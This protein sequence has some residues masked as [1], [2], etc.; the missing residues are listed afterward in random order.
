MSDNNCIEYTQD[1]PW[2]CRKRTFD[3]FHDINFD[4][5]RFRQTI[6]DNFQQYKGK[7]LN[8]DTEQ[9]KEQQEYL[10]QPQQQFVPRF[11]NFHNQPNI[12]NLLVFHELGSGKTCTSI[13]IGEAYKAFFNFNENNLQADIKKVFVVTPKSVQSEYYRE[14]SGQCVS[15]NVSLSNGYKVSY[16]SFGFGADTDEIIAERNRETLE[17]Y[18]RQENEKSSEQKI[19]KYWEITS[20]QKF[21]NRLF[22]G[23]T[24]NILESYGEKI[25]KGGY[26][27]IIDEIQNLVSET[28]ERYKKLLYFLN[29]FGKTNKIIL[30]S[31]TPIYDK[32]FELGL[33]IN[34]LNP[35]VFFPRTQEGFNNFFID[36]D[37]T[38]NESS[39]EIKNKALLQWMC[40][41]YVSYFSGGNPI[42]FPRKRIIEVFHRMRKYQLSNYIENV[43][44]ELSKNSKKGRRKGPVDIHDTYYF[45]NND[46]DD[47]GQY[48]LE[49]KK[50]SNIYLPEHLPEQN[51][52]FIELK[53][54]KLEEKIPNKNLPDQKFNF[55]NGIYI[56]LIHA[57]IQYIKDYSR[58]F[59]D[60]MYHLT[61]NEN[62]QRREAEENNEIYDGLGKIMIFSDYLEYGVNCIAKLLKQFGYKEH[63]AKGSVKKDEKRFIKWTGST[64]DD[65]GKTILRQFNDDNNINGQKIQIILGTRSIMEGISLKCVREVHIM[66]PWWNESRIN[67]V[68]ARAVRFKS[69][70]K[71]DPEKQFVNVF[72]HYSVYDTYPLKTQSHSSIRDKTHN[73]FTIDLYIKKVAEEK[74]KLNNAFLK[75]LKESSIDCDLNQNINVQRLV[76]YRTELPTIRSVGTDS[77]KRDEPN[78]AIARLYYK[79][80]KDPAD[81]SGIIY[82]NKSEI[83]I[84]NITKLQERILKRPKFKTEIYALKKITPVTDTSYIYYS[85]NN[86]I[87]YKYIP[88]VDRNRNI[89]LHG[90]SKENIECSKSNRAEITR[91]FLENNVF[92]QYTAKLNYVQDRIQNFYNMNEK[93]LKKQFKMI[94]NKFKDND[95]KKFKDYFGTFKVKKTSEEVEKDNIIS[96]I[97][98]KMLADKGV[99]FTATEFYNFVIQEK[100]SS[101]NAEKFNETKLEEFHNALKLKKTFQ[102]YNKGYLEEYQ[103][104]FG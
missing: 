58:K 80:F 14:I 56:K 21:L 64:G 71:L 60:L 40:T 17:Q 15:N 102:T 39:S 95:K 53:N 55:I 66:E 30:L 33:T 74:Q 23:N 42:Y 85:E 79:Y 75:V 45:E 36:R 54:M 90:I 35:R 22:K 68:I 48:F 72:K 31:A 87:I 24:F 34:L 19:N 12:G 99:K 63:K 81:Y 103:R 4:I 84:H 3:N 89:E 37:I 46:N 77:E 29:M 86:P 8:Y 61:I 2:E 100:T 44:E 94:I 57:K 52:F 91:D 92:V 93:E 20:H 1:R 65:E 5:D 83:T 82:T 18:Y 50:I 10:L 26:L 67:Q 104:K 97:L 6:Q 43:I 59:S 70:L 27:I 76:E 9:L 49:A 13:I 28:G 32:P 62:L 98:S 38:N 25:R 51:K 78:Y 7:D 73:F 41:G 69:H 88:V 101:K 11:S 96:E 16:S 47:G